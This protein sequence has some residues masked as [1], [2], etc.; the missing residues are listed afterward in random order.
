MVYVS[1]TSIYY[2]NNE[3]MNYAENIMKHF[4]YLDSKASPTSYDPS[5]KLRKNRG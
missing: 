1:T 4:G 2:L 3:K 5:F